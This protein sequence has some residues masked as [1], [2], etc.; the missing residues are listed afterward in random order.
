MLGLPRRAWHPFRQRVHPLRQRLALRLKLLDRQLSN[1]PVYST[2]KWL[3][4]NQDSHRSAA[5]PAQQGR[6]AAGP[7][8]TVTLLC[9]KSCKQACRCH[10]ETILEQAQYHMQRGQLK[11]YAHHNALYTMPKQYMLVECCQHR[12]LCWPKCKVLCCGSNKVCTVT[13]WKPRCSAAQQEGGAT[14]RAPHQTAV[15]S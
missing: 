5:V 3:R 15:A 8:H 12:P 2:T 14:A 6:R 7:L 1:M 9:P 11:R 13:C 10:Y 4:R